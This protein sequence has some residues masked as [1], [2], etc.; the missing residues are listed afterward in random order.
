[1]AEPLDPHEVLRQREELA[2]QL[3]RLGAST[4]DAMKAFQALEASVKK[5][6]GPTG[7]EK[8]QNKAATAFDPLEAE[9]APS[10]LPL[11]EISGALGAATK[12][13]GAALGAAGGAIGGMLG[14]PLGAEIGGMLPDMMGKVTDAMKAPFDMLKSSVMAVKGAFDQVVS[15][16]KPF[17]AAFAPSEVTVYEIAMRDLTAVIG[18]ALVPVMRLAGTIVRQFADAL[19]PAMNALEPAVASVT[20]TLARYLLPM[21]KLWGGQMQ[22]ATETAA[23]WWRSIQPM[24]PLFEGLYDLWRAYAVIFTGFVSATIDVVFAVSEAIRGLLGLGKGAASLGDAMK[25]LAKNAI[26]AAVILSRFVFFGMAQKS[27]VEGMKKGLGG[28]VT[29]GA[30]RGR[31]AVQNVQ[32]QSGSD[33]ARQVMIAAAGASGEA[34][35]TPEDKWRKEVKDLVEAA[36]KMDPIVE[37]KNMIFKEL[38]RA[39][40]KAIKDE[41][42]MAPGA[43]F[44][45]GESFWQELKKKMDDWR[46]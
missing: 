13:P 6:S 16:V 14:G 18:F 43:R 1:M 30:S 26:V 33:F 7:L 32:I 9:L 23:R 12:G 40:A 17:V 25:N 20:Q 36:A 31:A 5:A 11:G 28:D 15:T 37:L 44:L 4:E 3:E 38:P 8:L 29:E 39:I 34:G 46:G 22:L 41:M 10:N 24:M 45:P 2:E 35:E 19:M 42:L 21:L 27:F